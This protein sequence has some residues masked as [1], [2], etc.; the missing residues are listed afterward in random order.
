MAVDNV[1]REEQ[2]NAEPRLF[3]RDA[4]HRFNRGQH[5]SP[6]FD[7]ARCWAAGIQAGADQPEPKRLGVADGVD[8]GGL[9]GLPD[10]LRQRHCPEQRFDALLY[11][12]IRL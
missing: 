5:Q 2:R 10:L 6:V 8:I 9:I 12:Q 4:L 1:S 11:W 3:D 7:V